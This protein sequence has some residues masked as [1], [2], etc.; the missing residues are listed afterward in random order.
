[1]CL[2]RMSPSSMRAP[3]RGVADRGVNQPGAAGNRGGAVVHPGVGTLEAGINNIGT[4]R[5]HTNPGSNLRNLAKR[6][7][8]RTVVGLAVD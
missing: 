3:G 8:L 4:N 2:L 7:A 5:Q 6:I 1:M